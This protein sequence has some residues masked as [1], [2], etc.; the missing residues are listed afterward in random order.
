[1][2][3]AAEVVLEEQVATSERRKKERRKERRKEGREVSR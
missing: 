3:S 1:M 2:D